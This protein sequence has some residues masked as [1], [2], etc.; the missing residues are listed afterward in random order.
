MQDPKETFLWRN[1]VA[2]AG[3]VMLLL[4]AHMLSSG[5]KQGKKKTVE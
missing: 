4:A 2:L 1:R 5:V 3:G